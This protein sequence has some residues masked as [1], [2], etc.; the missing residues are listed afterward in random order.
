MRGR[1]CDEKILWQR[2]SLQN[3]CTESSKAGGAGHV[4]CHVMGVSGMKQIRAVLTRLRHHRPIRASTG[5]KCA[6]LLAAILLVLGNSILPANAEECPEEL[7]LYTGEE[8]SISGTDEDSITQKNENNGVHV[9]K[10]LKNNK[11]GTLQIELESWVS[12]RERTQIVPMDVVL[13]LDT[14]GSMR[15]SYSGAENRLEGLKNAA[16]QFVDAIEEQ[17][18]NAEGGILSRIALVEYNYDSGSGIRKSLTEIDSNGAGELRSA[19][20]SLS[21]GGRTR[22]DLG[23][24]Y[25]AEVLNGESDSQR[26]QAVILFTD[27]WP[28]NET[29]DGF[30]M[31]TANNTIREA[32]TLKENGVEIFTISIE[33][34]AHSTSGEVMPTYQSNG[35]PYYSAACMEIEANTSDANVY[36]L[37]NRFMYLVSS[38]NLHAQDMDTPNALDSSDSGSTT[39]NTRETYYYTASSASELALTFRE[40]AAQIGTADRS[41]G[42]EAEARD[43][44]RNPFRRENSEEIKVYT[45]D[46]LGDGSWGERCDVTDQ[47]HITADEASV[48]VSGFDYASHYVSDG[49]Q[50]KGKKLII[51][52]TI[53]PQAIFGGNNLPTNSNT[54]G[55][56]ANAETE[57]SEVLYPVPFADLKLRYRIGMQDQ[58]I[59]VPDTARLE[60]LVNLPEGW[61]PDGENNAYVQIRYELKE[62]ASGTVVGTRDVAAGE[63][64][65][66]TTWT[67]RT[68][69]GNGGTDKCGEY[70]LTCR[71]EPIEDGHY[72]ALSLEDAGNVHV[73]HPV[74]HFMDSTQYLGDPADV[75]VGDTTGNGS[76]GEHLQEV[77]WKCADDTESR[78]EEEPA[79]GYRLAVPKGLKEQDGQ[80]VIDQ[81]EDI[82]VIVGVYRS[83]GSELTTDI[84]EQSEFI[85]S[86][87]RASCGYEKRMEQE[88]EKGTGVRF[89][90]HVLEK[91]MQETVVL[92]NT[93]GEGTL[94][95]RYAAAALAAIAILGGIIRR[96]RKREWWEIHR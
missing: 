6:A 30:V 67:W 48:K 69:S 20:R 7:R 60:D 13:V 51:S 31:E 47:V 88:S 56:Y 11:D 44:I 66:E 74:L 59:Y 89:L 83:S 52:F 27:G 29:Y 9:T 63:R 86:C 85:H 80:S 71:M 34:G 10:S 95:Y 65:E 42:T 3:R 75:T 5:G 32:R 58:R 17:N 92:P 14:S 57:N 78:K 64:L 16:V 50:P 72:E 45:S 23:I 25:A 62:A 2:R 43:Y 26:N 68:E 70:I 38:N 28:S 81:L 53:R 46:Y 49:D 82:P 21:W 84:T 4:N 40:M 55:I 90:I 79:L 77:T 33:P 96:F 22:T 39:G 15:L 18:Q 12:G 87:E 76:L 35:Q 1:F 19:I 61:G 94:R 24:Q 8:I 36:A 73:F 93:G 91:P 54:S 41:L 37:E